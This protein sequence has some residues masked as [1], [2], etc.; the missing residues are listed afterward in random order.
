M[1]LVADGRR[2]TVTRKGDNVDTG[3]VVFE[4]DRIAIGVIKAHGAHQPGLLLVFSEACCPEEHVNLSVFE[5]V[6]CTFGVKLIDVRYQIIIHPLNKNTLR[7][8]KRFFDNRS[9]LG[10][11]LESTILIYTT[12][13]TVEE[14]VCNGYYLCVGYLSKRG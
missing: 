12:N 2:L 3:L 10:W 11:L 6:C 14:S 8:S 4:W 5:L 1:W 7:F 9:T 13:L